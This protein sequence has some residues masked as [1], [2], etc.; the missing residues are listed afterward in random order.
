MASG[1]TVS[2]DGFQSAFE[3]IVE[4]FEKEEEEKIK[5]AVSA[6]GR[7]ARDQLRGVS[8]P[9]ATGRYAAGWRSKSENASYGGYY[10]RVYNGPLYML[11][12]LLENGHE[13]WVNGRYMGRR[14]PAYPHIGQAADVGADK[15][16]EV[17]KSG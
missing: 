16:T 10:V 15:M 7:A 3:G 17:L 14:V 8:V 13:M 11:T 2:I 12:H 6:G 1:V 9:G 4:E 5:K